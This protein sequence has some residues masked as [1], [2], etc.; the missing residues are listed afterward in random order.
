MDFYI[1]K[2]LFNSINFSYSIES[3]GLLI[4]R[5]PYIESFQT[6]T[7]QNSLIEYFRYEI[8]FN[9]ITFEF[10]D[11]EYIFSINFHIDRAFPL[12]S[13]EFK[14]AP[15]KFKIGLREIVDR[16]NSCI[17]FNCFMFDFKPSFISSNFNS[18]YINNLSENITDIGSIRDSSNLSGRVIKSDID[19]SLNSLANFNLESI[20]P[21]TSKFKPGDRVDIINHDRDWIFLSSFFVYSDDSSL[22]VCC[23][24][25]KDF[26]TQYVFQDDLTLSSS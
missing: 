9:S 10:L 6:L 23:F 25:K 15:Y 7:S 13:I 12:E 5:F 18:I 20:K 24:I 14:F 16:Y 2:S 1:K 26:R 11:L 19:L 4:D 22:R 3:D 8:N 21:A 17:Y